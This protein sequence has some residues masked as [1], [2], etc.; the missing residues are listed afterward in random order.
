MAVDIKELLLASRLIELVGEKA[1]EDEK[2]LFLRVEDLI[3]QIAKELIVS[4]TPES[5]SG[6]SVSRLVLRPDAKIVQSLLV[7]LHRGERPVAANFFRQRPIEGERCCSRW[8][9]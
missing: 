7:D 8:G 6:V 3:F 1:G 4:E 9:V 5:A 2:S